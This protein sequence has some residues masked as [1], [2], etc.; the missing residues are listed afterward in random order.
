MSEQ[1]NDPDHPAILKGKNNVIGLGRRPA[2]EVERALW[3]PMYARKGSLLPNDSAIPAV[4][5]MWDRL[6]FLSDQWSQRA[7]DLNAR[8]TLL[9]SAALA[10][11][12]AWM[13]QGPPGSLAPWIVAHLAALGLLSVWHE[14]IGSF[15]VLSASKLDVL[16]AVEEALP[17]KPMVKAEWSVMRKRKYVTFSTLNR[18][19]PLLFCLCY[20]LT[21]AGGIWAWWDR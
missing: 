6:V 20:L 4:H 14:S 16:E 9:H 8:H 21:L 15:Q 5:Q 19:V 7:Q 11:I 13:A 3:N 1:V 12:L 10:G 2:T 17:A 18:A